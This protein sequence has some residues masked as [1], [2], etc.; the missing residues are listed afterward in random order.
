MQRNGFSERSFAF[1][2]SVI[3]EA[4]GLKKDKKA[5][6]QY[7]NDIWEIVGKDEEGMTAGLIEEIMMRNLI[8][9]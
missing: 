1:M 7:A 8:G 5:F 6:L 9:K 3:L 4:H 2:A